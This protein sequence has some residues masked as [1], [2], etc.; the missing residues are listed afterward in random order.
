MNESLVFLTSL[1]CPNHLQACLNFWDH[2]FTVRWQNQEWSRP[3]G[4][5]CR[6]GGWEVRT[7]SNHR[8]WKMYNAGYSRTLFKILQFQVKIYNQQILRGL[9]VIHACLDV[10]IQLLNV[11]G[12]NSQYMGR[13][14][15][16]K[17]RHSPSFRPLRK[18]LQC[19]HTF[20]FPSS[21]DPGFLFSEGGGEA[22]LHL[23]LYP[24]F[25]RA[26]AQSWST[27]SA[28][29]SVNCRYLMAF[30]RAGVEKLLEVCAH[31]IAWLELWMKTQRH[32]FQWS[33]PLYSNSTAFLSRIPKPPLQCEGFFFS[34][35]FWRKKVPRKA[36]DCFF[37]LF[38]F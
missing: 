30:L 8:L 25:G 11:L 21:C 27:W 7:F 28:R 2:G 5:G 24:T 29:D 33:N 23:F 35:C 14:M 6:L 32:C 19:V 37:F 10:T 13:T 1:S 9:S 20:L 22:P 38:F 4:S 12:M 3:R 15:W 26:P 18:Q 34:F 17:A 16:L 36:T 31:S